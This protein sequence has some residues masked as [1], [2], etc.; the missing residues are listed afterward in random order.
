MFHSKSAN[1][2]IAELRVFGNRFQGSATKTK[3]AND[4]NK[5]D[6]LLVVIS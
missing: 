4:E 6:D 5:R 2:I 1:A 3:Q